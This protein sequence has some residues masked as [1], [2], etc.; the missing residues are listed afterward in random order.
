MSVRR[1]MFLFDFA[2]MSKLFKSKAFACREFFISKNKCKKR[3]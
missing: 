3:S 1:F 2:A